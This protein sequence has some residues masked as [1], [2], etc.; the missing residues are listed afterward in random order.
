MSV[1]T[2]WG[3]T[4]EPVV[5]FSNG[6]HFTLYMAREP[7]GGAGGPAAAVLPASSASIALL[8]RRWPVPSS[9]HL[10][11]TRPPPAPPRVSPCPPQTDAPSDPIDI[12]YDSVRL[13]REDRTR[14]AEQ[15][16]VVWEVG[17]SRV[18]DAFL[19]DEARERG[20]KARE[21]EAL[22]RLCSVLALP[23]AVPRLCRRAQTR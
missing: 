8:L 3:D 18:P 13:L 11:L 2:G 5:D 21:A 22:R 23:A 14:A 9:L 17:L 16:A 20:E 7:P 15:Q 4:F 12:Q 1:K 10:R 19:T 6:E